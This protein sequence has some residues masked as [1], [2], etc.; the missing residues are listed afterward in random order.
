MKELIAS[1][2]DQHPKARPDIRS[3]CQALERLILDALVPQ[4][5]ACDIWKEAVAL[6]A[7]AQQ[8]SAIGAGTSAIASS[9]S[10]LMM[11]RRS[12][13][14]HLFGVSWANFE[15]AF[16]RDH[17]HED[18]DSATLE[19]SCTAPP[20][21]DHPH[22]NKILALYVIHQ[23]IGIQVCLHRGWSLFV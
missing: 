3:I 4:P 16:L 14:D 21:T 19:S 20:P 15:R 22:F 13:E 6:E 11:Q 23:L 18:I 12:V 10:A 17:M 8:G 7:T 5:A 1:C 2:L 9:S